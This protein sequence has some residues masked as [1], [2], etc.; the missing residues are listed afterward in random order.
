MMM[1]SVGRVRVQNF[2]DKFKDVACNKRLLPCIA[3]MHNIDAAEFKSITNEGVVFIE[4]KP[5]DLGNYRYSLFFDALYRTP[6]CDG[7]VVTDLGNKYNGLLGALN[8]LVDK[9]ESLAL[10]HPP[11]YAMLVRKGDVIEFLL[12]DARLSGDVNLDV[13]RQ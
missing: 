7:T 5:R 6:C 2:C 4:N 11:T 8:N 3:S 10:Q 9:Y 12:A 1:T 13:Q